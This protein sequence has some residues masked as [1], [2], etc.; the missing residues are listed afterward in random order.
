[1][2]LCFNRCIV[3][4]MMRVSVSEI[5][6]RTCPYPNKEEG[7]MDQSDNTTIGEL[8]KCKNRLRV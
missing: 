4:E 1:M 3:Q 5:R 7:M 6:I 2:W 8:S